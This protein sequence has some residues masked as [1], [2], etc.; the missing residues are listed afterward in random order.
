MLHDLILKTRSFRRFKEDEPVDRATLH[1]LVEL[2]RLGGSARNMQPLKYVL[3]S[4]PGIN[5]R[6]FP[7]LGW[8]GYLND[9][10]GP[11][12]GERPSAYI[13]C[14]LDTRL[15]K[16]ADC[17]LGIATQNIMLG[18]TEKGLGGCRIASVSPQLRS[19]LELAEQLHILLVIA[20][21][22]PVEIVA[23][24]DQE[25]PDAIKYW[26]DA[27]GIH[28]VPKRVLQEIIVAEYT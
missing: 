8:A 12:E 9:W 11:V 15:S 4:E 21:G 24:E 23:L 19:V 22:K 3:A 18:A 27:Q 5:A 28:H 7:L 20:L 6:I 10:P 25:S 2:A 17:D 1:Y 13:I 26:R 16:E 14:L